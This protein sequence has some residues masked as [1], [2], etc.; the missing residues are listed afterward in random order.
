MA[1]SIDAGRLVGVLVGARP[2]LRQSVDWH[3][4]GITET[5]SCGQHAGTTTTTTGAHGMSGVRLCAVGSCAVTYPYGI[6]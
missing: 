4:I 5:V 6:R 2:V 1:S 3:K